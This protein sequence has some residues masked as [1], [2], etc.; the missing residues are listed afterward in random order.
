MIIPVAIIP[1]RDRGTDPLRGL[2]FQRVFS[3]WED[4][5]GWPVVAASD[6]RSGAA[7]FNRSAA[8][9]RGIDIALDQFSDADVFI[10]CESDML[11]SL[12]Q[13]DEA[14]KLAMDGLGLVVPFTEYAYHSPLNSQ[15]IRRDEAHPKNCVPV[16]KKVGSTSIGA[17]N[18]VSRATMDAVGQFDESFEGNWYDDDAMKLAFDT[19]CG[20]ETRFVEGIGHHLYHLPGHTGRHLTAEDRAATKA[21]KARLQSYRHAAAYKNVAYMRRLLK[22]ES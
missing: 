18:V 4:E 10:F 9:N 17:V 19:I 3:S 14:C 11:V 12:D 5:H 13:I 21:N 16:W 15:A 2:N 1:F 20:R 6:G 22:G 8:Y 7:Q